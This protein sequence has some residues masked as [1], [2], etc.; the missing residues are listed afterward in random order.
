MQFLILCRDILHQYVKMFDDELDFLL[1]E[2]HFDYLHRYLYQL[3]HLS[4]F[5]K[6][7]LENSLLELHCIKC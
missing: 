2:Y 1:I 6:T 7:V 3:D 5:D 4:Y